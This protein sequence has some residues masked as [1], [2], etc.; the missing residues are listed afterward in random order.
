[1]KKQLTVG[2]VRARHFDCS[3]SH[4]SHAEMTA[5]K[6]QRLGLDVFLPR[7]RINKNWASYFLPCVYVVCV[8]VVCV[9]VCERERERER[10]RE[11]D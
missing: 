11:E 5:G 3:K 2:W 7:I 4:D 8:C 10:E 1:M 9:C 6:H